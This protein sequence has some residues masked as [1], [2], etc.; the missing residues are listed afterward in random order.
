MF[1]LNPDP[2]PAFQVN[3]ETDPET[4]ADLDPRPKV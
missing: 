3:A 1:G 2:E 4:V